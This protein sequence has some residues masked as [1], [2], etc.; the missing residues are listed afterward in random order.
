MTETT[1]PEVELIGQDSN[2]FNLL[3]LASKA[4]KQAGQPENVKV[5]QGR[6]M[7][8]DSYAEALSIIMEYVAVI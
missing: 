4:L 8:A 1:K 2:I 5:L 3:A 6:V 7:Q